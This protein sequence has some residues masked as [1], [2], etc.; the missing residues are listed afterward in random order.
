MYF[1]K[2]YKNYFYKEQ[3]AQCGSGNFR[4]MKRVKVKDSERLG[5]VRFVF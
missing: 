5:M 1:I 3:K 2:N 4:G